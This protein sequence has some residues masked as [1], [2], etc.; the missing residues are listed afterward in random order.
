VGGACGAYGK[1][2]VKRVLVGKPEGKMPLGR[3]RC[4]WEDNI[5]IDFQEVGRDGDWMDLAQ[6]R[7]RWRELVNTVM[8][9]RVP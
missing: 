1:G 6:N 2:G 8:H 3:T 4:R 5:K 7:D 9:L